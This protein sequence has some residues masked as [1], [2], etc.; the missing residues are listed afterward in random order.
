MKNL[1]TPFELHKQL[2]LSCQ[3]REFIFSSR[4]QCIDILKGTDPRLLLIVGPC[5]IQSIDS[6]IEYGKRIQELQKQVED[7]YLLVMRAYIEKSRSSNQWRGFLYSHNNESVDIEAGLHRS[8]TLFLNLLDRQIPL[9]SEFVDPLFAPFFQDC[10][11]LGMLG[12]RSVYSTPHRHLVS[13]LDLPVGIKNS[14]S[15]DIEAALHAIKVAKSQIESI[16]INHEGKLALETSQGNP[17][18]YVVLR[19]SVNNPNFSKEW[20]SPLEETL[21]RLQIPMGIV[22]DCSHGNSGKCYE[23]QVD[24]FTHVVESIRQKQYRLVRGLMLE[25]FLLPS[26]QQE[27]LTKAQTAQ[28]KEAIEYGASCVDGCIDWPTTERLILHHKHFE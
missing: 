2:P 11:T 1:T 17:N 4:Q 7:S 26:T 5:A 10:L 15:G 19:G 18:T 9:C 8:R 25:S 12:A 6:A 28:E 16:A 23:K 24:V 20:I 13:R 27:L 14:L 3:Q 22:I 21:D